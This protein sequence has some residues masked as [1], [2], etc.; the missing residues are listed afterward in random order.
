MLVYA[1]HKRTR[2]LTAVLRLMG[3]PSVA[4]YPEASVTREDERL[5]IRFG[6]LGDEQVM[7][8]PLK[9]VG[10]QDEEAAEL[11]LLAQLQRIGYRARRG[12]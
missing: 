7:G 4:R 11:Q 3:L 10:A 6:G 12:P 9:Y 8:V 5:V 2:S 1:C